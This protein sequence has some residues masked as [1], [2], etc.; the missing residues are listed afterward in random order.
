MST[1]IKSVLILDHHSPNHLKKRNILISEN[2]IIKSITT[3]TPNARR[4][5]EGKNLQVT[6]G[7]MDMRANFCDPGNE[8]KEDQWSGRQTAAKGGF[9]GV[10][11]LPNTNPVIESK[12][13]VSYLRSQNQTHVTQVYPYGA[14]TKG[15][16]GE[17][18]TEMYDL[19]NAGA[20][21]FTD[22]D[23]SIWNTD[24]LLKSLQYLEKLGALLIN[25]PEDKYLTAYGN[26]NEGIISTGLGLKG[27]PK[28]AEEVM[29][30]RD[31]QLLQ[32]A[33]GRLHFSNIS[34]AKALRM[35]REAKKNG[36]NVTCDVALYNLIWTD[37]MLNTYETNF[38]VNPPLREE[39]DIRELE[40][41]IMDGT[42]DC[43][44]SSHN[45]QDEESKRLEFDH[46]DF[47]MTGL[48]TFLP[49]VLTKTDK[50][51]F[52]SYSR[53]F[54]VRPREILGLPVPVI[55]EGEKA[56][57]TVFDPDIKWNFNLESNVSKSK[58]NPL[59]GSRLKGKV[60]ATFNNGHSIVSSD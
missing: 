35:V 36:L 25:K 32:Y 33:G 43:I 24:I 23:N 39:A 22:G 4:T 15:C 9:T 19:Y 42:V 54:T 56:D 14:V 16:L 28:L 21:A 11:L 20:V 5:I 7:W 52:E 58:N 8:H 40:K 49:L 55:K 38:K 50:D 45:P 44:V 13:E 53:L 57:L 6:I 47:G 3:D 51:S 29:V 31:L 59:L 10:A 46:A 34:S 12:N 60:I 1:L 37:K 18:L 30:R 27:M 2:G 41:G 26:M 48:Q 17:E